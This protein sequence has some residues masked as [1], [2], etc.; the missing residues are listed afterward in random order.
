M[1]KK[2]VILA[3]VV[4]HFKTKVISVLALTQEYKFNVVP[5][6]RGQR[7]GPMIEVLGNEENVNSAVRIPVDSLSVIY[8]ENGEGKTTLLLD[9]CSTL[10]PY[11]L[12]RPLGTIWRDK[13]GSIHLD[14]GTR[15]T[16]LRLTGPMTTD[17]VI[18]PKERFG[19]VFYTTS[20]FEAARR[21]QLAADGTVD[22]TP[23]FGTNSFNGT[24]L[25]RAV[26]S[27]PKDIPFIR[28]VKVQ[29]EIPEDLD[30]DEE[31]ERLASTMYPVGV[32]NLESKRK[33]PGLRYVE[34]LRVLA[35]GL[36]QRTRFLLAIELHRARLDGPK[37]TELLLLDLVG[38]KEP[39]VGNQAVGRFLGKHEDRSRWRITTPHILKAVEMFK[40]TVATESPKELLAYAGLLGSQ[41]SM[42]IAGLQEAE[43]LGL[44]RWR[45]LELSSGQVALLMLFASLSAALEAL[46]SKGIRSVVLVV[47]EGEMF[48]HP[49]W[50]RKY[51]DDL[52]KFIK[53]YRDSFEEIHLILAT[54]SLI[55]AGDA[56]P[57]RLFDV[58]SGEMRNSFAYGPKEVLA[59]VYGVEEFSGDI[60]EALY[61]KIVAF[62]GSTPS[63]FER[64]TEVKRLIE[65]IASPKLRNYLL[66]ELQRRRHRQ[67]A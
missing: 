15:L 9:V 10:S 37:A 52:M 65:Q 31:I 24:S 22:V 18:R 14:P 41:R 60:A 61:E 3:F 33:P 38:R 58:K 47:D 16:T 17:G 43:N 57:N 19:S 6:A 8:G 39:L 23:S 50:Q 42:V 7:A 59:D 40:K 48:M 66:E 55:V 30:I 35:L 5:K 63:P 36:S 49:A 64:E 54:H 21:R 53:H 4:Q 45:F 20:P 1:E 44:L 34:R 51:L 67:H 13:L 32:A 46:R 25:C 11:G 27:L 28:H 29:L 2:A 26:G 62:L 56:P 12:E